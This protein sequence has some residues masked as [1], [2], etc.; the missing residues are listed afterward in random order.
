MAQPRQAPSDAS[1][2]PSLTPQARPGRPQALNTAVH[3]LTPPAAF[4]PPPGTTGALSPPHGTPAVSRLLAAPP[5]H[6]FPP[7]P[8]ISLG[9]PRSPLPVP[10]RL[11]P[12]PSPWQSRIAAAAVAPATRSPSPSP[13]PPPTNP[14]RS[15]PTFE[16]PFVRYRPNLGPA[17]HTPHPRSHPPTATRHPGS[18]TAPRPLP[19]ADR[20]PFT[21]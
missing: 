7:H 21:T 8:L 6:L 15:A 18:L 19:T 13:P 11:T 2:S 3:R 12:A 4:P 10:R 1:P 14:N 5:R 17:T 16:P 20:P 9:S